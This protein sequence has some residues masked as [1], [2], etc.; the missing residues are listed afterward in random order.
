MGKQFDAVIV[1]S[2]ISG[3]T[4]G[5]FLARAGMRV[6]V[7]ERHTKI[8]GYAH[9]FNRG[10]YRFESG[11]HSVPLAPN[12]LIFHLLRLLGV[13][14]GIK[15]VEH[16]AMYSFSTGKETYKVPA[17]LDEI[18]VQ[19]AA[20]FPGQ[21][22]NIRA[23]VGDMRKFYETLIEP[24]FHFEE[25]FV[26]KNNR[27]IA[28]YFNHSYKSHIERF[29]TDERLVRILCSQWPFWG[30]SP[31]NS[32][33]IYCV[34]A[35]YVHALEGSH[36]IPGGF[37]KLADSLALAIT[38][39]GGVVRTGAEVTRMKTEKETVRSVITNKGEEIE[40]DLYVSNISPYL[41]HREIIPEHSR[42]KLWL[43]RLNGLH[44]SLSA[45]ALYFGLHHPVKSPGGGA[46]DF[47]FS[48]TDYSRLFR[49]IVN[50]NSK[51]PNHLVF[52]QMLQRD[53]APSMLLFSF[54]R[55]A[56]STDRHQEKHLYAEKMIT[57]ADKLIPGFRD[58]IDI[59][60]IASPATFERF[61]GNTSGALYGFE[62]T[63]NVYGEAKMPNTTYLKNLF[64]TGHWCKPG[65]G[66]WNV[67]ECGYTAAQIILH[68]GK[69][70]KGKNAQDR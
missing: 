15:A 20:D 57:A 34:L 5:A 62:N 35:F 8:G 17:N 55:A 46:L 61:S 58:A 2:G 65:G 13:E 11:I 52:L 23:L 64:Q 9:S 12:G 53:E 32:P 67:M 18:V 44:P 21:R 39:R 56:Q 28:K 4:C 22:S 45:T 70:K 38:Q 19:L 48:E 66:V 54:C 29:I 36:H 41:L 49:S 69:G 63:K 33:T 42:N 31:E 40:A 47:W 27:F 24:L 10:R 30:M 43:R 7:C 25:H 50:P 59:M 1:G 51:E 3:L 14:S 60:E 26:E 6:C 37:S 68:R 16:E